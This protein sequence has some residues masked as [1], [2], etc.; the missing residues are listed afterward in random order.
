MFK[1]GL[2]SFQIPVWEILVLIA[3]GFAV[4]VVLILWWLF[5]YSYVLA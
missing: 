4:L 2:R 5:G 1:M 3:A